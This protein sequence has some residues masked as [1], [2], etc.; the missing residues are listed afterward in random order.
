MQPHLFRPWGKQGCLAKVLDIHRTEEGHTI[1]ALVLVNQTNKSTC[2]SITNR[3][4]N[5][6]SAYIQYAKGSW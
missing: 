4:F 1:V 6:P 5:A 3:L 2:L